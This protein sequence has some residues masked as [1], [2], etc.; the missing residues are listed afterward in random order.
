MPSQTPIQPLL[1]GS[2][3]DATALS[4][5]LREK[6]FLITAIR[7]PTVREGEARLRVTLSA[8]HEVEDVDALLAAL[9]QCQT[10]DV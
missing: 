1:I 9:A 7:P 3:V 5:A 4:E 10:Q 8:A 6:G 2:D